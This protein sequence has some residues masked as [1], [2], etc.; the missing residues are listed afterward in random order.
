MKKKKLITLPVLALFL[1]LVAWSPTPTSDDIVVG[2]TSM[3]SPNGQI[4]VIGTGSAGKAKNALVVGTGHVL[5][6]DAA[7]PERS[8]SI[9]AGNTNTADVSTS[10]VCGTTNTAMSVT[11]NE[12][13][14]SCIIGGNNLIT[15]AHAYVLGYNNIVSGD[16]GTAIGYGLLTPNWRGVAMGNYNVDMSADDTFVI[17]TG[18]DAEHR[19]TALRVTN[20][21]GV[22]LGRAQGDISMG[23]YGDNCESL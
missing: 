23:I 15:N 17:G 2:S 21:G 3:T 13:R 5:S 22:I 16:Y 6:T 10:F 8:G 1:G 12:V 11:A 18:A 20:D 19:F 4:V 7:K 14:N 9:V